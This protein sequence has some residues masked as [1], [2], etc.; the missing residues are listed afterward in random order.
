MIMKKSIFRLQQ[1]FF[2]VLVA[3]AIVS[4]D[5]EGDVPT[6]E[7]EFTPEELAE[8]AA[9]EKFAA[10]NSVYR[11]LGLL[12]ELPDNWESTT[13]TPA[14]GVPVSEAEN[15]VRNVVSTGADQAKNYFLSIVPDEGLNGDTWSHEGV[16]TLTFQAV[17]KDNCYA[18]I[19]EIGRAHV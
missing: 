7:P 19:D 5:K 17:N 12:N 6:P 8:M 13:F 4:C 3:G 15:D 14:E 16:G 1:L 9:V 10:A 11:A 18:V 2:A